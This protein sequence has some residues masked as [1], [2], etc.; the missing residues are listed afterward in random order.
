MY[1][2]DRRVFDFRFLCEVDC[3]IF[4]FGRIFRVSFLVFG[5]GI[6]VRIV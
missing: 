1:G 6:E 2:G 5:V 4:F 3:G